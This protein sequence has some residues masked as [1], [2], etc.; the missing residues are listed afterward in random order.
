M[1]SHLLIG[2][3]VEHKLT[4]PCVIEIDHFMLAFQQQPKNLLHL[5][6]VNNYYNFFLDGIFD[7]LFNGVE[8][9]GFEGQ[10]LIL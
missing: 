9:C 10:L 4:R 6:I 2:L 8:L 5:I 7:S 3:S 1:Q